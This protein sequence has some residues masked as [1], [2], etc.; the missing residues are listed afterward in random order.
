MGM[1][2]HVCVKSVSKQVDDRQIMFKNR[3]KPLI[4]R[5]FDNSLVLAGGV[6]GEWTPH[7]MRRTGA[8]MMQELG[9]GLDVIDRCQNHILAGSK[10]RRHYL[11]H[12]YAKEKA[13]AWDKLGDRLTAILAGGADVISFRKLG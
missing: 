9:I 12:D 3:E 11:K 4:G 5:A 2:T 10:V 6:N 13:E 7:D 8:T 1:E